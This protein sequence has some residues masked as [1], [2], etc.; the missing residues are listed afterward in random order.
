MLPYTS[1]CV[2]LPPVFALVYSRRHALLFSRAPVRLLVSRS[3]SRCAGEAPGAAAVST[4]A[5]SDVSSPPAT[6][7]PPLEPTPAPATPTPPTE[8]KPV[9]Q[10]AQLEP[11]AAA[12]TPSPSA[13]FR[14]TR[15]RCVIQLL[16]IQVRGDGEGEWEE[17]RGD[18]EEKLGKGG[19][20]GSAVKF[21]KRT[22]PGTPQNWRTRCRGTG[23]RKTEERGRI[24]HKF[25]EARVAGEWRRTTVDAHI[26]STGGVGLSLAVTSSG[27][28]GGS[29]H[30]SHWLA[31]T[32]CRCR[33]RAP[34]SSAC[35]PTCRHRP[36][37]PFLAAS[38]AACASRGASTPTTRCASPSGTL[39]SACAQGEWERRR[40][41]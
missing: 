16:L 27:W 34:W 2:T 9:A 19:R 21:A 39:V 33:R 13:S 5:S 38:D 18:S 7:T 31:R 14:V 1:A 35:G 6:S 24:G 20:P 12:Q 28:L 25:A 17:G 29:G 32:M 26:G 11:K 23:Q 40:G 4:S 8:Q 10:A 30:F 37:S 22:V 36:S 41:D 3:F 15:C